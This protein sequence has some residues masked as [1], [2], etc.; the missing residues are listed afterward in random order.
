VLDAIAALQA[1]IATYGTMALQN[2]NAVA[3]T[4]GTINGTVIGGATPAA[5]TFT[6]LTATGQTSLGGAAGAESLR[7]ITRSG[8]NMYVQVQGGVQGFFRPNI[9]SIPPS[10]GAGFSIFNGGSGPINFGT[11]F[12]SDTIT[13]QLR[14]SHTASAVNY[15]QV[16][17]GPTGNYP[18]ISATG[19]D[20]NVGLQLRVKG[21]PTGPGFRI[22]NNSGANVCF[23][24]TTSGAN[25]VNYI[26]ADPA[27]AGSAAGMSSQGGDTNIDLTL[28]PKGT[29]NVRFG[30][31]TAD[32]TLIVQGFIEVKDSGG[33]I[34]KLAVIA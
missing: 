7:A 17:G 3:I 23:A 32:M 19:S 28:T 34:R 24:V 18:N 27:A 22:E 16:T 4:G 15:V 29:G 1:T 14:V 8:A 25:V 21:A 10:T 31:Y 11:T 30:T 26:R 13:E 5:G 9:G 20:A 6:T 2:A 33:T 12:S